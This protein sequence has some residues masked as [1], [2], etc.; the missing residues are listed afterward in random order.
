[1]RKRI[2]HHVPEP[3]PEDLERIGTLLR[4][5]GG[6]H[7]SWGAQASLDIWVTEQRAMLDQKM[8]ERIRTTPLALVWATVGLVICTAGLIWATFAA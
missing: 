4:R 7:V 3:T 6:P 1:M 2:S 5:I 8:S